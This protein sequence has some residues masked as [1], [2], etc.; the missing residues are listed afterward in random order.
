MLSPSLYGVY[1]AEYFLIGIKIDFKYPSTLEVQWRFKKTVCTT[2]I[3]DAA[4]IRIYWT[5]T[6]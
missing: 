6:R 2:K 5:K 4:L 1:F 3:K